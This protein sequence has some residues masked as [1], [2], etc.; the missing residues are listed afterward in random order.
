MLSL[1][2]LQKS[3]KNEFGKKCTNC[4]LK[5]LTNTTERILEKINHL[6]KSSK[7]SLYRLNRIKMLQRLVDIYEIYICK[8]CGHK[9]KFAKTTKL[10]NKHATPIAKKIP[11]ASMGS[12]STSTLTKNSAKKAAKQMKKILEMDSTNPFSSFLA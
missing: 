11:I 4:C 1:K 9:N 12:T 7:G 3:L 10:N 6:E 2:S 8:Y 5:T